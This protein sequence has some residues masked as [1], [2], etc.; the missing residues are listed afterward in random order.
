MAARP[1][2]RDGQA[3]DRQT[4]NRQA[5]ADAWAADRLAEA[6]AALDRRRRMSEAAHACQQPI[7]ALRLFLHVVRRRLPDRE[8][9]D[10]ADKLDLAVDG[11]QAQIAEIAAAA[12]E[13]PSEVVLG[14]RAALL[15]DRLAPRLARLGRVRAM[16]SDLVLSSDPGLLFH[17]IADAA[18]AWA[19]LDGVRL[20]L[21]CRRGRRAARLVLAG[22]P[23]PAPRQLTAAAPGGVTAAWTPA[24]GTLVLTVPRR[25]P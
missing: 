17:L 6:E 11:I 1:R 14:F 23:L 24:Q 7:Q 20:V 21:G 4:Q 13:R 3:Q 18:Q 19:G 15:I 22:R 2:G 25:Q 16:P 9:T 10:L 5:L 12:A 8:G